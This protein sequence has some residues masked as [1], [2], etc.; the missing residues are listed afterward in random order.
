MAHPPTTAASESPSLLQWNNRGQRTNYHHLRL[1]TADA[2]PICICL[3]ETNLEG[4]APYVPRGFKM[5]KKKILR[6]MV[7]IV[8]RVF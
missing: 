1:L 2:N 6:A 3:Q 4:D 7:H 5:Y 8:E